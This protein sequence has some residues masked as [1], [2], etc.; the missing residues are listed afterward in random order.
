MQNEIFNQ[1]L[2]KYNDYYLILKETLSDFRFKH[3]LGVAKLAVEIAY[4]H[5]YNVDDAFIAGLMHDF[6]KEWDDDLTIEYLALKDPSLLGL[7]IK[8]LHQYSAYFYLKEKFNFNDDIL[9]AIANHS[10]GLS[11][12]VLAKIIYIADKYEEN[13]KYEIK[14]AKEITLNNLD[15]GFEYALNENKKYRGV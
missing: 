10:T 7:N 5:N 11:V 13:R 1:L 14:K 4:K 6:T 15:E 9:D 12:R 3:S 8:I 2:L